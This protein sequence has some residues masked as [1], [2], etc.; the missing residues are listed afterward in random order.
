[1]GQLFYPE[2]LGKGLVPSLRWEM[3][4][5]GADDY[6]YLW[7]LQQRVQSLEAGG[8]GPLAELARQAR[9]FLE[10]AADGVAGVGS[11]IETSSG[12]VRPNAQRQSVPHRI[13]EEAALWLERLPQGNP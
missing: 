4:R 3:M 9:A 11:E 12:P 2:P 13:R 8:A 1:M 10:H 6:A 7:L 5:K